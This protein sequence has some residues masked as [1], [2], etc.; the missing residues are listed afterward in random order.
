LAPSVFRDFSS[1]RQEIPLSPIPDKLLPRGEPMVRAPSGH[2]RHL[3][4]V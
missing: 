3:G 1:E 4:K 2:F